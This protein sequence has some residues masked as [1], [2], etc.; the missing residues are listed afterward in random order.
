MPFRYVVLNLTYD[1]FVAL[2]NDEPA[3]DGER[4]VKVGQ[5]FS[6][7]DEDSCL[8]ISDSDPNTADTTLS[9]SE[10]DKNGQS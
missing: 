9:N 7:G 8:F 4:K 10:S 3:K 5:K 2:E 1:E 6:Y